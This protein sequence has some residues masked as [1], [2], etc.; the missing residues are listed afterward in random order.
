MNIPELIDLIQE[1]TGLPMTEI[2]KQLGFASPYIS[3]I[4]KKEFHPSINACKKILE[5]ARKYADIHITMD[6]L[7]SED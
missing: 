3:M 2:S 6:E 1:K 7:L 5:F 4:Q